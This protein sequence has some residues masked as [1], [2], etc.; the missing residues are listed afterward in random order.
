MLALL[1]HYYYTCLQ[2]HYNFKESKASEIDN[3]RLPAKALATLVSGMRSQGRQRERWIDNVKEDLHQ[4]GSDVHMYDVPEVLECEKDRKRCRKFVH[5][6]P[7]S[8]IR[9]KTNGSKKASANNTMQ[10]CSAGIRL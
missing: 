8:A 2:A 5:A 9:V 4:R 7:S 1:F 3:F 10:R 6:A